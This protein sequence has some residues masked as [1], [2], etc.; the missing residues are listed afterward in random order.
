MGRRDEGF[1]YLF[2]FHFVTFYFLLEHVHLN[3][4][5]PICIH[6]SGYY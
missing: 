2:D 3:S 1:A 4:V 5:T 6:Y